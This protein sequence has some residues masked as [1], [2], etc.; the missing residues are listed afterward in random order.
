M[1]TLTAFISFTLSCATYTTKKINIE[2]GE[3][4]KGENISFISVY[5]KSGDLYEF[6]KKLPAKMSGDKI[7][8]YAINDTGKKEAVSI[9]LSEIEVVWI[10]K[11]DRN[12]NL[13][14][15]EYNS[16]YKKSPEKI[17][18]FLYHFS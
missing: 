3:F 10:K 4:W 12:K 18:A 7:V 1:V 5:T 9:P 17:G 16:R 13:I 2:R 6:S 8:G 14:Q 15:I 11:V